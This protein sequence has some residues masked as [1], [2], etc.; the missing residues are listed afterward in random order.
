MKQH[1]SFFVAIVVVGYSN[2]KK[3]VTIKKSKIIYKILKIFNQ[4]GYINGFYLK[5][6]FF[7]IEL[8]YK[9]NGYKFLN[10]FKNLV[11]FKKRVFFSL[12]SLK[13]NYNHSNFYIISS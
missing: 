11:I 10:F 1:M 8:K 6:E 5:N 3:L 7:I 2:Y 13:R 12:K 4:L 9:L